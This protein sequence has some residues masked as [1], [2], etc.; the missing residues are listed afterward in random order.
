MSSWQ[1]LVPGSVRSLLVDILH[2]FNHGQR[3]RRSLS[4]TK[5]PKDFSLTSHN[6]R[7]SLV[8]KDQK[9][10]M[11]SLQVHVHPEDIFGRQTHFCGR[12]L[13]DV[14]CFGVPFINSFQ[15]PS[16]SNHLRRSCNPLNHPKEIAHI[17]SVSDYLYRS[18]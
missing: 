8:F 2:S 9:L 17:L 7:R 15:F 6:L 3:R 18:L 12:R 5:H 14:C 11:G 1:L 13:V 16:R 4:W 10:H